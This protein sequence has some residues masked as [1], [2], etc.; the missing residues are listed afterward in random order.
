VAE[1]PG[2]LSFRNCMYAG[3]SGCAFSKNV[4]KILSSRREGEAA[5]FTV[6]SCSFYWSTRSP[7]SVQTL[8]WA[9][10]RCRRKSALRNLLGVVSW[11]A[12]CTGGRGCRFLWELADRTCSGG[13]CCWCCGR[14]LRVA[15]VSFA[16]V[17]KRCHSFVHRC[18]LCGW[19]FSDPVG[20]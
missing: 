20:H 11:G 5:E 7:P 16:Y 6:F 9:H 19:S 13:C 4:F 12:S 14:C 17:A 3:D 10:H 15:S 8:F 2:W 18:L 1:A